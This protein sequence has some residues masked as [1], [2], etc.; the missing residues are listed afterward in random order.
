MEERNGRLDEM[1]SQGK[2][3]LMTQAEDQT[4]CFY[5]LAWETMPIYLTAV[6]HCKFPKN[7]NYCFLLHNCP[8]TA[9]NS[10][11]GVDLTQDALEFQGHKDISHTEHSF[12]ILGF[13]NTKMKFCSTT[14]RLCQAKKLKLQKFFTEDGGPSCKWVQQT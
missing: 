6:L 5:P 2:A 7:K 10:K 13:C 9:L 8:P 1:C 4:R 11:A 3:S 14:Q 12:K